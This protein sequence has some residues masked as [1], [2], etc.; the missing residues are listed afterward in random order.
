VRFR[1][2]A[3]P[4]ALK[5]IGAAAGLR[6]ASAREL[7]ASEA[8]ALADFGG[9]DIL[10]FERFNIAIIQQDQ[11]H[12][13]AALRAA[14]D[15]EAVA[16]ARPER[17]F[18]TI[19]RAP[20]LDPL[21][22]ATGT[23][24][25]WSADYLRGYRDGVTR[26]VD[27]LLDQAPAQGFW[28]SRE[29]AGATWGLVA[30][31]VTES[32]LSGSGI[33]LA[34]LDTGM[35]LGHP[36]FA[37]RRVVARSFIDGQPVQDG[38]G[39]GTHCI[40]TAAGPHEPSGQPRYGIAHGAVIHAGKVLGDDGFGSDR[41]IIAGIDWALGEGCEVISMSL[42]ARVQPG[43]VYLQDYEEIAEIC[44]D[45]GCLIVA[46]A[47]NDSRRPASIAPVSSPAN[48]PSVM[49]V[50]AIDPAVEVAPFSNGGINAGQSVDIV[51]PGV[52]VLSSVPGG[53]AEFDGTS[54]ATPHVAGVAALCAEIDP[55]YR[56][57][58]LWAMLLQHAR[59]LVL[60]VRDVG[61]GLLQA[62]R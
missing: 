12:L 26:L 49:A 36:D 16:G 50:G 23:R 51:A 13:R 18:R 32:R 17:R 3:G 44:L 2:G 45:A 58:A 43:E 55:K 4:A 11:E 29:L 59:P 33:K 53:H 20:G 41:S 22:P 37:G 30:S 39:H 60:P 9:A 61:R 15:E 38:N 21:P 7:A 5:R 54:M 40:G 14:G 42:G 8:P 1:S 47:G 56:G 34:V 31:R 6:V 48:C 62:P 28:E 24:S 52:D 25:H 46:A 10:Y 57:R 35:D 27:H 19:G